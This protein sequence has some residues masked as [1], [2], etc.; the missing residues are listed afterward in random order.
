[1]ISQDGELAREWA[2]T[3][4]LLAGDIASF[5]SE[6]RYDHPDGRTVWRLLHVSLVR[7]GAGRPK[8]LLGQVE[9]ITERKHRELRH[10]HD[11]EHDALT[12]AW[13]RAGMRRI[14]GDAWRAREFEHPLALLFA[15]LDG[16]KL[17]NDQYGHDAGDE[18]LQH[19]ASRLRNVV[20]SGDEVARWG[21]DEFLVLC[22]GVRDA[23]EATSVA[24]RIREAIA[25]PFRLAVGD[26]RIGVS[27]GVALEGGHDSPERVLRE[28]DA[29]SYRA[30]LAG[31]DRVIGAER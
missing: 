12:G 26:V 21:G 14:L 7:D 17:V 31:R 24:E 4:R 20:R 23:A 10:R 18:V 25:A 9:D 28:A 22:P 2:E 30:K 15:D 19:V 27:V 29:A 5:T 3:T 8:Q 1:M 11:A 6:R 16:F 13:N